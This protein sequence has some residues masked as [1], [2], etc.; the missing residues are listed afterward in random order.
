[1]NRR[2]HDDQP[3]ATN[4]DFEDAFESA[5]AAE[6]TPTKPRNDSAPPPDPDAVRAIAEEQGFTSREARVIVREAEPR[7]PQAQINIR[8][9]QSVVDRFKTLADTQRPK[10][11]QGYLLERALD[12]LERELGVNQE[13]GA[14]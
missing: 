8:A 10:W 14:A 11:P 12:A 9:P 5:D 2:N 7:P 1:M 3:Q 13:K 4:Y 6:W